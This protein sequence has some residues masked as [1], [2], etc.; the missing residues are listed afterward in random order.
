MKQ[1]QPKLYTQG[2]DDGIH[3]NLHRPWQ[4]SNQW[5]P[6]ASWGEHG[7][8]L[9][10]HRKHYLNTRTCCH[11]NPKPSGAALQTFSQK[12]SGVP[13]PGRRAEQLQ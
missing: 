4:S 1:R 11:N 8:S 6:S 7:F 10:M 9:D 12:S 5:M 3:D 2:S 13:R